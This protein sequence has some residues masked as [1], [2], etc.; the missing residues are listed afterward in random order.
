MLRR[1]W[2]MWNM[3]H[4]AVFTFIR[5]TACHR[6]NSHSGRGEMNGVQKMFKHN[7]EQT[8]SKPYGVWTVL[9]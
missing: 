1:V 8:L 9:L 5:S 3:W 2:H 4:I 7:G 6:L